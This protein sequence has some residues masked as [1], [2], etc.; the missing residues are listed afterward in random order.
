MS[1]DAI[2]DLR[3]HLKLNVSHLQLGTGCTA[4]QP[5]DIVVVVPPSG[6]LRILVTGLHVEGIVRGP[7]LWAE[8]I[9]CL[10]IKPEVAQ[11]SLRGCVKLPSGCGNHKTS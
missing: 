2:C 11:F 8:I 4:K 1:R 3:R 10:E 6:L 9:V 5:L 7:F